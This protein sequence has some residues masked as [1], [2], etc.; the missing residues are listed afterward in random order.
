MDRRPPAYD[1]DSDGE[2]HHRERHQR[3]HTKTLPHSKLPFY[4]GK[5][6]WHAFEAK[7]ERAAQRYQWDEEEQLDRLVELLTGKALEFYS[8]Q[9]PRTQNDYNSLRSS[10]YC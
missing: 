2:D 5:E 7:F 4:D 6:K 1:Q 3:G 9:P 10:H 8:K